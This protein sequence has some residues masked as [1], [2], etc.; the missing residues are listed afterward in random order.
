MP[1]SFLFYFPVE[2]IPQNKEVSGLEDV[3]KIISDLNLNYVIT[4]NL[5]EIGSSSL[6]NNTEP[7]INDL[8]KNR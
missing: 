3:P 1:F 2:E 8:M 6:R 7:L 4:Q 5:A